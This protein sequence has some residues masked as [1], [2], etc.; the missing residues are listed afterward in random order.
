MKL[1]RLLA[2]LLCA[3]MIVSAA[4]GCSSEETEDLAPDI[5]APPNDTPGVTAGTEDVVPSVETSFTADYD[6]AFA[7]FAPDTAMIVVGDHTVTWAELFFLIREEL[8]YLI[9]DLGGFPILSAEQPDGITYAEMIKE[10]AQLNAMQ[11]RAFESG[12]LLLGITLSE[13]DLEKIDTSIRNMV[14][15]AGS[16]EM[17]AQMLWERSCVYDPDLYYYLMRL[18]YLAFLIYSNQFGEYGELVTDAQLAEATKNDGYVMAKHIMR[19][20]TGDSSVVQRRDL[21]KILD[22]LDSYK[23][24]NLSYFFD[25]L[26]F[27]HSEDGG[28]LS[29]FPGGYLFQAGDLD[30]A[31]YEACL[32]LEEGQ[33]SGILETEYAFHILYRVPIVYDTVPI[34]VAMSGDTSTLRM[35][36]VAGMFESLTTGWRETLVPAPVFTAEFESLDLAAIFGVPA[37]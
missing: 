28:G 17:F 13:D 30:D 1:K 25:D 24:D 20:K 33:Y 7:A 32:K 21:R 6:A 5:T 36:A 11:F 10:F 26:M 15:A 4:Y 29:D 34:S 19:E 9:D 2:I 35:I 31:F 14:S 37:E 23:G 18:D 22:D 16:E 12:A 27:Q 3:A 8:H